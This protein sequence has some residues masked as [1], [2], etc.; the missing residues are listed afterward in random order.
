MLRPVPKAELCVIW[1]GQGRH[2]SGSSLFSVR[3]DA[4]L[5]FFFELNTKLQLNAVNSALFN[6]KIWVKLLHSVCGFLRNHTASEV[7]VY[8][9]CTHSTASLIQTQGL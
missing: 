4:P 1:L 2:M 3:L 5:K 7:C 8:N 9:T 6:E